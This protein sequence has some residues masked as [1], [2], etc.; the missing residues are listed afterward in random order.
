MSA[1]IKDVALLAGVAVSTVSRVVNNSGYA[2]P[3]TRDR[4]NAAINELGFS[5]NGVARSLSTSRGNQ[6]GVI[7]SDITNPYFAHLI[8]AISTVLDGT[9][10]GILIATTRNDLEIE[11]NA[12]QMMFDNRVRGLIIA[13][14]LSGKES[15]S[16]H[17]QWIQQAG[18]PT[19]LLDGALP[20]LNCDSVLFDN[21]VGAYDA[22]KLLL[23]NGHRRIAIIH[24]PLCYMTERDRLSGY[25]AA[26][27]SVGITPGQNLQ[28]LAD[29]T[30]ESAIQA[31]MRLIANEKN[32]PTA[33]F[34]CSNI[35]TIF[36]FKT[37][38]ANNIRVPQDIALI[39]SDEIDPYGI[40]A[41][42]ITIIS[43]PTDE[44]GRMAAHTLLTKIRNGSSK[45]DTTPSSVILQPKLIPRGSEVLWTE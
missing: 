11:R 36:C 24:G 7:V 27:H 31:T 12:I 41:N 26:L 30:D 35:I 5:P 42:D 33:V 40:W 43:Q 19:V 44:L 39:G 2:K 21:Y 1:T 20:E 37:L 13:P 25:L 18:I 17:L 32:M 16:A 28:F 4:V 22:T 29:T 9:G 15:N 10:F 3:E 23:T 14:S 45:S 8:Q 38:K 6:I 34:C